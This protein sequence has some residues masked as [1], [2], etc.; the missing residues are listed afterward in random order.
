MTAISVVGWLLFAWRA[1][2]TFG[3]TY[4][5]Y[6]QA[7]KGAP[8]QITYLTLGLGISLAA[9]DFRR[10]LSRLGAAAFATFVV[11]GFPIG[12][13][14]EVLF[15]CAVVAAVIATRR[16][17]PGLK[18]TLPVVVLLLSVIAIVSQTRAGNRDNVQ[19]SPMAGLSEMGSSLQVVSGAISWHTIGSEP[20]ANG[21]S[22]IAP[23]ADAVDRYL[24]REPVTPERQNSAYMSTQVSQRIGSVGG[25][26]IGEAYHNFSTWGA[27][28]VLFLCGYG[29]GALNRLAT[30]RVLW[31]AAAIIASFVFQLL[32]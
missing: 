9:I 3:S 4:E 30:R 14:G 17:M 11:I 20:F 29:L 12:L 27:A 7:A 22:Y 31:L 8:L 32:V 21:G 1:R 18:V 13:R 6:L 10:F 28:A 16:S 2:L 26:I 19:F 23:I 25:S 24:L 15:P 5:E